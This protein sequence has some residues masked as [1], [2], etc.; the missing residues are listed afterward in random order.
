MSG[1]LKSSYNALNV[2]FWVCETN[3]VGIMLIIK[4]AKKECL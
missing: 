2:E 4:G 3:F 1:M